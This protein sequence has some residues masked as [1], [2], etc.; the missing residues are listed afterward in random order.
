MSDEKKLRPDI[1]EGLSIFRPP[2]CLELAGKNFE[3]VMDDGFDK[4]LIVQDGKTLLFGEPG[5]EEAYEYDC[6]KMDD[7]CYLVNFEHK[8]FPNPRYGVTIVLDTKESLV[9]VCYATLGRNPKLPRMPYTEIVFGAVK[10][11]DGSIPRIRH[12]YTN[13]MAGT[14]IDWDYGAFNIAHIYQNERL[15]RVAFTP[16]AIERSLRNSPEM[17]AGADKMPTR[18]EIYEDYGDFVKIRDGVYAVNILETNLCRRVGHGNSLF[19]LMNL[20]EMHDAGRSFGT[21]MDG[22]DE[23]YTFGAFGTWYDATEEMNRPSMYYIH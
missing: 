19:F 12:G 13:E 18:K 17:L 4:N 5:K 8:P 16:R 20:N 23:N 3:L 1:H 15:Y 22:K 10:R 9:T 14:S 7:Q 11:P 2:L 6:I 21:N